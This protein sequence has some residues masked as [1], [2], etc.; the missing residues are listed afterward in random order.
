MNFLHLIKRGLLVMLVFAA[1]VS[2]ALFTGF[3]PA[4]AAQPEYTRLFHSTLRRTKHPAD[5]GRRHG[6]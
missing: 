3:Q 5:R 1:A 4:T 6:D 2:S